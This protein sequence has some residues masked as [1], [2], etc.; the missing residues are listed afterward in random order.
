MVGHL[1]NE[2]NMSYLINVCASAS[3][4]LNALTGGSYRNTFSARTGCAAYNRKKWALL[5][6]EWINKIPF[7]SANHCYLEAKNEGLL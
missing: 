2:V 7:F 1:V 5:A 4:V 6:E 3:V